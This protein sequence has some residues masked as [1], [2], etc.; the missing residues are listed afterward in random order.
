MVL[1]TD[2]SRSQPAAILCGDCEWNCESLH[3]FA[4]C[5][6]FYVL[7]TVLFPFVF[8]LRHFNLEQRERQVCET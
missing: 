1:Y 3:T 6:T 5:Y 7:I 4:C 2:D 8:A